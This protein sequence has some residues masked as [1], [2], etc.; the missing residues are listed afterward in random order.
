MESGILSLKTYKQI[1]GIIMEMSKDG[2]VIRKAIK[3]D[4]QCEW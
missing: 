2:A 1:P 4:D 3:V